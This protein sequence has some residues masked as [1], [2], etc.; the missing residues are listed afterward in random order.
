MVS[1]NVSYLEFRTHVFVP[2]EGTQ[3]KKNSAQ[4]NP[5]TVKHT[6][7]HVLISL[8]LSLSLS[9]SLS[10]GP[11]RPSQTLSSFSCTS[12]YLS[13]SLCAY[14]SL[15]S[16]EFFSSLSPSH[17][18]C[19]FSSTGI[20]SLDFLLHGCMHQA[21][22]SPLLPPTHTHHKLSLKIVTT[23]LI[24]R[25]TRAA[26]KLQN[27][28]RHFLHHHLLVVAVSYVRTSWITTTA[29]GVGSVKLSF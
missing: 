22:P 26:C 12:S 13:L 28:K 5:L 8:F 20:L 23:P 3:R 4:P 6:H 29:E 21:H 11:R 17:F 25:L 15:N 18:F 24:L 19:F 9:F 16:F 27:T 1:K 2:E 10:L 7:G 14:V